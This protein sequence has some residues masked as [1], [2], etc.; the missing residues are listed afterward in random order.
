MPDL[1]AGARSQTHSRY[2]KAFGWEVGAH[3]RIV[4]ESDHLASN[5]CVHAHR[6]CTNDADI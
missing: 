5:F 3:E 4:M 1:A 6:I 2:A